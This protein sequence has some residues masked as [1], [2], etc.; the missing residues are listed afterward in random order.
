VKRGVEKRKAAERM[1]KMRAS[2]MFATGTPGEDDDKGSRQEQP[3][4]QKVDEGRAWPQVY[5]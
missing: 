4:R 5:S 1:K 3:K 2:G